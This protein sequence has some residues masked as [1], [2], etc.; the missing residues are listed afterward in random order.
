MRSGKRQGWRDWGTGPFCCVQAAV[1]ERAERIAMI[2][3][4]AKEAG[5]EADISWEAALEWL[6]EFDRHLSAHFAAHP[7]DL[8][9]MYLQYLRLN[10]AT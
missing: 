1:G 6:P 4:L 3:R 9:A 7:E 8:V 10:R 2:I 5:I